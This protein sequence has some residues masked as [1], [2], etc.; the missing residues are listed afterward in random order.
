[1]FGVT[2]LHSRY[3]M[4]VLPA[5]ALLTGLV[6]GLPRGVK[7]SWIPIAALVVTLSALRVGPMLEGRGRFDHQ[8][9]EQNWASATR[10]IAERSR[11]DEVVLFGTRFVQLDEVALGDPSAW[12]TEFTEWPVRANLPPATRLQLRPLPYSSTP[13]TRRQLHA[14][15]QDASRAAGV[16]VIGLPPAVHRAAA[17]ARRQPDLRLAGVSN[18]GIVH[19][20]HFVRR[21][22]PQGR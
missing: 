1:M 6:A 4:A 21:T 8:F 2:L 5:V 7:L 19:V 9:R 13:E 18:H 20:A 17:L 10:V 16:W 14:I 12:L 22:K 3:V 11:P 15:V